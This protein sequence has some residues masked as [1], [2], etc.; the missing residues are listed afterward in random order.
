MRP[1][2]FAVA[3]SACAGQTVIVDGQAMSEDEAAEV[4]LER[5]EAARAAGD[6][7][8]AERRYKELLDIFPDALAVPN[9]L[10]G[11]AALKHAQG[12]C[13]AARL[14]DE[15]LIDAY[16][17]TPEADAA[18]ARREAC[19][20]AE[21]SGEGVAPALTLTEAFKGASSDE[22]KKRV[23]SE[24][25]DAA[26]AGGDPTTAA[27]WLFEVQRLERDPTR[28][29]EIERALLDLIRTRVP[30]RG[31]RELFERQ[32]PGEF[33]HERLSYRLA[34][35]QAHVE[36]R[37]GAE[38]SLRRHLDTYPT[39]PFSADARALLEVLAARDRFQPEKLGVLLPMS[40]RHKNYG[41]LALQAIRMGLEGA[42]VE[43]VVEDT[44]S[45]PVRAAARA[46]ALVLEHHVIGIL[47]PIF[48][49]EARPAAIEAQRL[50]TPI[51]TISADDGIVEI[52]PYVFRNGVTNAAQ[53]EALVG[54]AMD[55]LGMKR[56]AIMYPRH[57]YGEELLHLF[58]D[59]VER[60][61][62][63]ITGV[64]SY[65]LK[66]TTFSSQVKSLVAR[67]DVER[68][69]DY[70][71]AVRECNKQPDDY[72]KARCRKNVRKNLKPL[73]DFDG[74]FIPDYPRSVSMITAAL[75]FEDV[76]VERDPARLRVIERTLDRKVRPV[77]LLGASGWN[78]PKLVERSDRNVENAVF[79][80][81][82]FSDA[83]DPATREFV[84]RYREAHGRTPRLYPEA[85][86]YDSAKMIASIYAAGAPSSRSELREALHAVEG[87]DGVT[88]ETSFAGSNDADKTLRILTI[89]EGEIRVAPPDGPEWARSKEG[90]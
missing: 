88:G 76:I 89:Q 16:P 55:V 28:R 64:E 40:G 45:D 15:R 6:L 39:G 29:Q 19:T 80:D 56:F 73:I 58:W 87:F 23:A 54:Y 30:A 5:A 74:L 22:E 72:R 67:D 26:L 51:L 46:R 70:L 36:D 68:R 42:S 78:S 3:F 32:R 86:F 31:L 52:G 50:G 21:Q 27:A 4:T 38:A 60:R 49:Y 9:A 53:T 12:G 41:E 81:G 82:F 84:A 20:P 18:R 25:A 66:D 83:D 43:L 33:L 24:A 2:A 14:Y 13:D 57:P 90:E 34:R 44:A 63:E 35:I 75:A 47:G 59:E 17:R 77:T 10:E 71:A 61:R 7:A 69:S 65:G 85:L 62:G 37:A 1:W 11:L 8:L 48:T 79:T